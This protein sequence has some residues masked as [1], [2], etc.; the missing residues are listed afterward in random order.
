MDNLNHLRELQNLRWISLEDNPVIDLV[1]YKINMLTILPD[2][3]YLDGRVSH[4][5]NKYMIY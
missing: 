1:N 2:I 3:D 4:L 5:I